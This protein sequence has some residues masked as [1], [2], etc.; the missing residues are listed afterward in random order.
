MSNVEEFKTS[1]NNIPFSKIQEQRLKSLEKDSRPIIVSLGQ[2]IGI[3]H[4]FS[5]FL[6]NIMHLKLF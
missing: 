2:V 3:D 6:C 1:L 4:V 5:I